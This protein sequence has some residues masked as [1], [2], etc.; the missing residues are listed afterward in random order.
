MASN[1]VRKTINRAKTKLEERRSPVEKDQ[2][3]VPIADAMRCYWER[4]ML[5]F[6]IPAH[7]GGRGPTPEFTRWAGADAARFDLPMSHGVDTTG[8]AKTDEELTA[9]QGSPEEKP[10]SAPRGV[11]AVVPRW[12]GRFA[13]CA[14]VRGLRVHRVRV[15]PADCGRCPRRDVARQALSS[16]TIGWPLRDAAARASGARTALHALGT[17]GGS[18]SGAWLVLPGDG[19]SPPGPGPCRWIPFSA[20][21]SLSGRAKGSAPGERLCALHVGR[22]SGRLEVLRLASTLPRRWAPSPARRVP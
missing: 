13:G 5:S 22:R 17:G 15:P 6:A 10:G 3:T 11:T 4:D 12:F 9:A 8:R 14:L 1:A 18:A 19:R 20:H 7:N 16:K 2:A 21:P